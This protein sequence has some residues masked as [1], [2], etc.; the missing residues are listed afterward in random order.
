[1]QLTLD[2]STAA[3]V[4]GAF[5]RAPQ[6]LLEELETAMGSAVSY[7]LRET[8]EN[9]PTAMGT[10]RRSFIGQVDVI[11]ML[12][13][14][15]GTVSSP[16]PYALPVEVGT[17]PHHPPLEPLITWAQVKLGLAGPEAEDAARAIQRKIGRLGTMAHGMAHF[18]LR[19]GRET[20]QAEIAEGAQRALQRIGALQ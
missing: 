2:V 4:S 3:A 12:D 11:A 13:S 18:A 1:M 16:L 20:I 17:R 19:D 8:Q 7:L 14:V 15:F 6:I 9:T 10:L 5:M